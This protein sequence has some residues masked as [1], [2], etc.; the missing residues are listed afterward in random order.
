MTP[1]V[2]PCSPSVEFLDPL[3]VN[4]T[5]RGVA[6]VSVWVVI[7]GT[8]ASLMDWMLL[9][10]EVYETASSGQAVT[11][12]AYGAATVVLATRFSTRFLKVSDSEAADQE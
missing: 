4:R 5:L 8:V 7:W 1:F 11:F 6:Y 9:T 12:I 10:G 2:R 3:L